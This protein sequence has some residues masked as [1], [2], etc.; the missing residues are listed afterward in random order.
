MSPYFNRSEQLVQLFEIY[1]DLVNESDREEPTK[2]KC[3]SLIRGNEDFSDVRFRKYQSDLFKLLKQFLSQ[4]RFDLDQV[5]RDQYLV[6]SVLENR[7]ERLYDNSIKR[8]EQTTKLIIDRSSNYFY[9]NFKLFS[10][11][12]ELGEARQ[13]R[14]EKRPVELILNFLEKFYLTEKYRYTCLAYSHQSIYNHNY[15]LPKLEEYSSEE[16]D[17]PS[18]KIYQTMYLTQV[19]NSNEATYYK[20]RSLL[21]S[22]GNIFP[23]NEAEFIYFSALNYCIRK[24]NQ[25]KEGFRQEL[26]TLYKDLLDKKILTN[27]GPLSPWHFRNATTIALRLGDFGWVEN[28]IEDYGPLISEKFR[29]N[30]VSFNKAQLY[31]HKKQYDKVIV[32]LQDI[33]YEDLTYS[34]NSKTM[35]IATYYETNNIEPLY[36]LLDSFRT[37]LSRHKDIASNKR[38]HYTNLI[39]LTK[40]LSKIP[41]SNYSKL[42][43]LEEEVNQISST[44]IASE[45]WLREKIAERLAKAK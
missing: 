44:G 17:T 41:Y 27:S 32:T 23:I 12:Y 30:A 20:L 15:Q 4:E 11:V 36:S 22:Y 2:E 38:V 34:L 42:K 33:E 16:L 7:Y 19:D 6:D 35:L 45:K 37:Y 9:E 26:F 8:L 31:M 3:W 10:K 25:G 24:V 43:Q 13:N 5:K 40:K 1:V 14:K 18:L 29:T 21:Q 39:K 28:F